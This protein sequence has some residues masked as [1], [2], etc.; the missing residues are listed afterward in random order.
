MKHANVIGTI[1]CAVIFSSISVL[2]LTGCGGD[3]GP[4]PGGLAII[5][6]SL[7]DGQINQPYSASVGG[8]EARCRTC[9]RSHRRF[10]PV[11]RS[12]RKAARSPDTRHGGNQFAY[13]YPGRFLICST[14]GSAISQLNHQ[15]PA[16][17]TTTS[18]PDGNIGAVYGQP[19][20]TVGGFGPLTFSIVPPRH[21]SPGSQSGSQYWRDRR[22][23]DS[24]RQLLIHCPRCRHQWTT[25]HARSLDSR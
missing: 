18:L 8:S 12:T 23:G 14:N 13:I 16:L 20:Q 1:F 2:G 17:I 25:G 22:N 10:L 19:I 9:G 15:T 4:T 7:P 5:T 6:T 3:S 21:T 24:N 11:F